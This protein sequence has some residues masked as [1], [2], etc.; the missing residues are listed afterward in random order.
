M[1]QE[2]RPDSQVTLLCRKKIS[3]WWK[4]KLTL[5][6]IQEKKNQNNRTRGIIQINSDRKNINTLLLSKITLYLKEIQETSLA[7]IIG[8]I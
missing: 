1:R 3:Q 8:N 2:P 5:T 6:K 7:Q 4:K